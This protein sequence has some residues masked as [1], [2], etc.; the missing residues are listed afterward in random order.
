MIELEAD[1][2]VLYDPVM[3]ASGLPLDTGHP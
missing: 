1:A 2:D 3:L